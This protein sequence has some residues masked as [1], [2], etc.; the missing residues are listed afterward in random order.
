MNA[1][2]T[3]NMNMTLIAVNAISNLSCII[4]V[5]DPSAHILLDKL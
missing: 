5:T 2:M 4:D 1:Y 3:M